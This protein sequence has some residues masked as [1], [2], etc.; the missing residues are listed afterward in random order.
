M[1][2]FYVGTAAW[3][4]PPAE[5]E[6]RPDGTSHLQHYAAR[7]N[8]VE[9]NS[10]FYRAHQRSTYERWKQST[11]AGFRF[12]V[13][14]PRCVTHESALKH[15][16]TE[17]REFQEQVAGLGRKLRI[18]LFQ[19]PASLAFESRAVARLLASLSPGHSCKIAWEPRH[20]SW[21][22]AKA[23]EMLARHGVT[24]VVADP[25]RCPEAGKPPAGAG[26]IYY[27]LHGSPRMY[28]S[29]YS[30]DFLQELHKDMLGSGREVWC[31]F[32]NT[33]RHASWDNAR[34]LQQLF[35]SDG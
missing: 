26:L 23:Q 20:P 27:R 15:C 5:R 3:T 19:T 18:L 17:L 12:S 35:D 24:R 14:V 10:S 30:A 11:P 7:F 34:Y 6:A 32:D 4:N 31:I 22:T 13:K 28:Y 2:H 8:A 21:F 33:A 29:A 1:T 16:R 25:A 9:I